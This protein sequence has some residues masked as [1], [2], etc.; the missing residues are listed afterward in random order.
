MLGM[1]AMDQESAKGAESGGQQRADAHAGQMD[2]QM[3]AMDKMA[4]TVTRAAET[5]EMMMKKE[6]AAMPYTMAA[7]ITFGA[8]LFTALALL[9]VLEVQW[10]TYWSRLLKEQKRGEKSGGAR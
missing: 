9:I 3:Q 10:I 6:M 8:M 4:N 5:C 1:S 2:P 7:A